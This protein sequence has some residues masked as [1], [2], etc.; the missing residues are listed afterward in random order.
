MCTYSNFLSSF[1][2]HFPVLISPF[3]GEFI[4]FLFDLK[5][6]IALACE[7]VPHVSRHMTSSARL[8]MGLP[9]EGRYSIS[10]GTE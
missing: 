1:Q 8:G 5:N 2:A 3:G 10:L 6:Q 7:V 9:A 4:S